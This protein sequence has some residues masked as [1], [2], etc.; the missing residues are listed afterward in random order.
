MLSLRRAFTAGRQDVEGECCIIVKIPDVPVA[1]SLS[2]AHL[3]ITDGS[4]R[5]QWALRHGAAQ[6]WNRMHLTAKVLN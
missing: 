6:T 4:W 5:R 3:S 1:R 2:N